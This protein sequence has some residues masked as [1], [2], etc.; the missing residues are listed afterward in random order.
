[1]FL[2]FK[3]LS[4]SHK[5][6]LLNVCTLIPVFCLFQFYIFPR[7]ENIFMGSYKTKIK[8][9]VEIAHK[10]LEDYHSQAKSGAMK[11]DEAKTEAMNLIKNLR[12]EGSE[13]FW[14]HDLDFK[15]VMH[16]TS[17]KIVGTNIFENKDPNGFPIFQEM[18]KVATSQEKGFVEYMWPKPGKE[19]PVEKISYVMLFRPWG[20]VIG[21]GI[22][23]DYIRAEV[24]QLEKVFLIGFGVAAILSCFIVGY[25]SH[26]LANTFRMVVRTLTYAGEEMTKL[27]DQLAETGNQVAAGV[28]ESASS[29]QETA[30]SM[31]EIGMIS[32][33]NADHS[34]ATQDSAAAC[35]K[36]S[37]EGKRAIHQLIACMDQ[38][39]HGNKE[40]LGQ[41]NT[42]NE[43]MNEI[44][45]MINEIKSKTQV[46]NDIVFQT[47][48]LSFNA[49]VE[50]ARAGEAGKGFAVVAEEVG[51]LAEM[52]GRAANEINQSLETSIGRIEAIIQ[53]NMTTSRKKIE[54]A[55]EKILEG[56][57]VVKNCESVFD[58][59]LSRITSV[60]QLSSEI[61]GRCNE[62]KQGL[63]Q[64]NLA[65]RQL[66]MT[67][68]KN[69]LASSEVATSVESISGQAG[70]VLLHTKDIELMIEGTK[71]VA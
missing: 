43:K 35:L 59:I 38:I 19:E 66:N 48:L 27:S 54:I 52:S 20:M 58:Q 36:A 7:V 8:N 26:Q 47:K 17:T 67:S 10:I 44:V 34:S 41:N 56:T 29:I 28:S 71:K 24:G 69:A 55:G 12:Y 63:E 61:S 1:M 68:Q 60:A 30:A 4:L 42:S 31:E 3:K 6:I 15:M 64:M 25:F 39:I 14:I 9:T 70:I 49:S 32:E 22:Y 37:N 57:E 2:N 50:S 62:Q 65:L 51:N 23:F 40:V 13:Y 45:Q 11:E 18:N 53:E 5:L 16:P 21:S 33:K 46:I